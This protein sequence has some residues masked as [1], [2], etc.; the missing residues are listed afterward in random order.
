[1]KDK[2]Q[3]RFERI[4]TSMTAFPLTRKSAGG[5]NLKALLAVA[6]AVVVACY[7]YG[8][9]ERPEGSLGTARENFKWA[10]LFGFSEIEQKQS[11]DAWRKLVH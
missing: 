8:T 2:K 11:A 1:M 9:K 7:R 6:A 3:H 5:L 10:L 4:S